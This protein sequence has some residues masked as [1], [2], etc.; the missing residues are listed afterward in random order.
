ML[1]GAGRIHGGDPDAGIPMMTKATEISPQDPFNTWFIG[2][3][4][5]G[6]LLAGH[7]EDAIVDAREAIKT[8]YGYL[9]G[10]VILTV[11]L[12]QMGRVD[13]ARKELA[14]LLQ[15]DPGFGS[16]YLARY[17]LTDDQRRMFESS[18]ETAGLAVAPLGDN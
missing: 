7:Y 18:L 2:G 4:A 13:D 12:A 11:A 17:T 15:I 10:R 3:R 6:Q 1:A 9:M 16:D 14:T 5:I 8:R